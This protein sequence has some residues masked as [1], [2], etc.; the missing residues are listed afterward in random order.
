MTA[1]LWHFTCE[2]AARQITA[3]GMVRP[4]G[5]L[6]PD[7]VL[8]D[9]MRFLRYLTWATD[10]HC[11]DAAVLGLTR[12]GITCDRTKVT[13]RIVQPEQYVPW[14]QWAESIEVPA[15][16][17]AGMHLDGTKPDHWFVSTRSALAVR[18]RR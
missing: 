16:V 13:Y 14:S 11:A 9:E 17:L 7:M 15:T 3:R 12:L 1:R 18:D 2:H 6:R 5:L 4:V 10:L 8:P